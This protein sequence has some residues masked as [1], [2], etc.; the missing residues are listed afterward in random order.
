M[1]A[2]CQKRT[3]RAGVIERASVV[4]YDGIPGDPIA[5]GCALGGR[6]VYD[7]E[8]RQTFIGLM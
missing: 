8:V 1:S 4:S 5:A 3:W 6:W 2:K 7:L